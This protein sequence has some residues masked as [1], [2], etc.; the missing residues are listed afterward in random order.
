MEITLEEISQ[1]NRIKF[2]TTFEKVS[3]LA[4]G[5]FGTVIKAREKGTNRDVAVKI[6]SKEKSI[7]SAM[8]QLKREVTVLQKAEHP[9]IVKLYDF[10]ET[11]NEIYIVMEYIKSG[12][13]KEYIERNKGNITE[14][15]AHEIIFYLLQKRKTY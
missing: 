2:N 3:T 15:Q 11:D 6:I 7:S 14:K 12:T 8:V 10:F 1:M 5:A 9:N 4:N 13:L